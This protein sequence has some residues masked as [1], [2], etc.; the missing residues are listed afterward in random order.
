M[1]RICPSSLCGEEPLVIWA[2][3]SWNKKLEMAVPQRWDCIRK[4]VRDGSGDK[5]VCFEPWRA[6]DICMELAECGHKRGLPSPLGWIGPV[7]WERTA[8]VLTAKGRPK[9]LERSSLCAPAKLWQLAWQ[10]RAKSC[11]SLHLLFCCCLRQPNNPNW[12]S[13]AG[14]QIV[15]N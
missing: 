9:R 13:A 11:G 1:E 6:A 10:M 8:Y 2:S 4:R 5:W 12:M 15:D 14:T 7:H 3:T